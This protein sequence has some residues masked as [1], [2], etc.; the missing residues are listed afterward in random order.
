MTVDNSG[1]YTGVISSDPALMDFYTGP[2]AKRWD[3]NAV[4][5]GTHLRWDTGSKWDRVHENQFQ[6]D[7]L[8]KLTEFAKSSGL[9]T[10]TASPESVQGWD[11]TEDRDQQRRLGENIWQESQIK[12][13]ENWA[14]SIAGNQN[15]TFTGTESNLLP[16][17]TDQEAV[18]DATGTKQGYSQNVVQQNAI[19]NL[20]SFLG[21]Y[22]GAR[23]Q[24]YDQNTGLS[25]EDQYGAY[26]DQ[27]YENLLQRPAGEG[28]DAAGK[29][30]W[31]KQLTSGAAGLEP[32]ASWKGYIDRALKGSDEYK[33][34]Q[35]AA[36]PDILNISDFYPDW[37]AI[38]DTF[39]SAIP[40]YS[41][42]PM[43]DYTSLFNQQDAAWSKKFDT[44]TNTY[45]DQM[46]D[47]KSVFEESQ[48][49]QEALL[50][51]Y[52]DQQA[53][54]Q[55]EQQ[56][57]AAYGERAM[58]QSVK[59]VKTAN[60]LPGF[61]PKFKGTRGHFNRTGSRLTTGALNI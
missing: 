59:G 18:R 1:Q 6:Q 12:D 41:P 9:G 37:D 7:Q 52:Q 27:Q 56:A 8:N 39:A 49:S 22:E 44:L 47:L 4:S 50:Q 43:P 13:L 31:T 61:Q 55:E 34:L 15:L 40:T 25:K 20:Q 53:A 42:P 30:F 24:K 14:A 21:D 60:E 19:K 23:Q 54:Y 36:G 45:Q 46:A 5:A 58:N 29:E 2:A 57:Q 28:A 10:F 32:G 17:L 33:D 38:A 16:S 11:I 3:P 26:I 48:R 51:G 35:V